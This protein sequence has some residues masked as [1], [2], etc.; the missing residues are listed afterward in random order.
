MQTGNKL[1]KILGLLVI[2]LIVVAAITY[3]FTNKQRLQAPKG[4]KP[5]PQVQPSPKPLPSSEAVISIKEDSFEPATISIS[6]GSQ[7]TWVNKD[8]QTHQIAS[9]LFEEETLTTDSSFTITFEKEGTFTYHD[10]LNPAKL[11]GTIIV[12]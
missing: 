7:V 6:K 9:D 4:G 12:K 8:S 3:L 2:L 10:T 5:T 1:L 11:Q